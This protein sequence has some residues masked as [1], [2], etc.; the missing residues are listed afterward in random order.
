MT[1]KYR[2][3]ILEKEIGRACST[4]RETRNAH[5]ILVG[6]A[7]GKRS[8]GRPKRRW[9]DNIKIDLREMDWDVMDWI[10]LAHVRDWWRALVNTVLNLRVPKNAGKL[11]SCCTIG[12]FSGMVQFR[13]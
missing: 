9:S 11:L 5:R 7:E 1:G 8:L 6:K 3:R 2:L 12:S 13:K 10:D 4:N